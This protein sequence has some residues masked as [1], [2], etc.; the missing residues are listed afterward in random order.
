MRLADFYVV[1]VPL[2][3]RGTAEEI[4]PH[5]VKGNPYSELMPR[6]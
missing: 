4:L 3:G 6:R 1:V 2:S 5:Y